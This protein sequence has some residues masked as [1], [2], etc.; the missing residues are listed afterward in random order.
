MQ[1]AVVGAGI[2]AVSVAGGAVFAASGSWSMG[3]NITQQVLRAVIDF[4]PAVAFFGGLAVLVFTAVPR[5]G[6]VVW[7]VYA[8]GAAIAYL[9]DSLN[10]AGAVRDL[11]P[12]HLI[13][14][15]PVD[16]VDPDNVILLSA[17][18]AAFL[19]AGYASF[20]RRGIPEV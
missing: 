3:V 2:V 4:L 19:V 7:L 15:P 10:L 1:L 16:A 17:L 8:A 18:T 5:W 20:R 14:N 9:G 12:F 13:G 6:S 11:S